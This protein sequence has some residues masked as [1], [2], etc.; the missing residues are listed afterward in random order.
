VIVI[1][2][3]GEAGVRDRT[4]AE[5]ADAVERSALGACRFEDLGCCTADR[6]TS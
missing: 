2:N 4:S 5:S 1:L 6:H 3:G